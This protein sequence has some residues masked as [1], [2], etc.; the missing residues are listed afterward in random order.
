MRLRFETQGERLV[1]AALTARWIDQI[2]AETERGIKALGIAID[3]QKM[4]RGNDG[5]EEPVFRMQSPNGAWNMELYTGTII[6]DLLTMDSGA[7][8][9]ELDVRVLDAKF[10]EGKLKA[11]VRRRMEFLKAAIASKTTE[12]FKKAVEGLSSPNGRILMLEDV[13]EGL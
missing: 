8:T 10:A 9:H 11:I 2:L 6:V 4:V 7:K 12:E 13:E 5:I 1:A 3:E